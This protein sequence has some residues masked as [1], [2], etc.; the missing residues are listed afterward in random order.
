MTESRS[1]LL[2]L[3]KGGLIEMFISFLGCIGAQALRFTSENWC[4]NS[5]SEFL[6][7]SHLLLLP[8]PGPSVPAFFLLSQNRRLHKDSGWTPGA[9]A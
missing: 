4:L 3:R 7:F 2:F 1:L 5:S 9:D 8:C 6:F